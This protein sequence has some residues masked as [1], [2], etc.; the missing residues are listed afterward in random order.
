MTS[1][2]SETAVRHAVNQTLAS[3]GGFHNCRHLS[4]PTKRTKGDG[5]KAGR[6]QNMS[7]AAPRGE[8]NYYGLK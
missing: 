5:V 6:M 3:I 8:R 4:I 2:N 1:T 7:A